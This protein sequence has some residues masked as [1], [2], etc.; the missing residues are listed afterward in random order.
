M[1]CEVLI[2]STM[3]HYYLTPVFEKRREILFWVPS[4]QSRSQTLKSEE[5]NEA[6]CHMREA[7]LGGPGACSPRKC[8]YNSCTEMQFQTPYFDK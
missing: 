1:N 6:E 3:L 7:Y 4:P 5:A 2:T 8:F